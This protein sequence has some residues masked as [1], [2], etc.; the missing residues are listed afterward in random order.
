MKFSMT[1]EVLCELVEKAKPFTRK[2]EYYSQHAT[3]G[4]L[5]EAQG[6]EITASAAT[7]IG[8]TTT[9]PG[10][11]TQ[12]GKVILDLAGLEYF[13]HQ[14]FANQEIFFRAVN[15]TKAEYGRSV[16]IAECVAQV[17][18]TNIHV[19]AVH[20]S[21]FGQMAEL[22]AKEYRPAFTIDA[23]LLIGALGQMGPYVDVEGYSATGLRI[24]SEKRN[25]LT[26]GGRTGKAMGLRTVECSTKPEIPE[27][28]LDKGE[29]KA[30]VTALSRYIKA[31]PRRP[32]LGVAEA[33]A[34]KVT[35][36]VDVATGQRWRVCL[37]EDTVMFKGDSRY[38]A[39]N[40]RGSVATKGRKVELPAKAMADALR[41]LPKEAADLVTLTHGINKPTSVEWKHQEKVNRLALDILGMPVLRPIQLNR[42]LWG[43]V[44]KSFKGDAITLLIPGPDMPLRFT[45]AQDPEL[46]VCVSQIGRETRVRAEVNDADSDEEE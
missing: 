3:S 22:V 15:K 14:Q 26:L 32:S 29:I 33:K 43:T 30:L 1:Q 34:V 4:V 2:G 6:E 20:S 18:D 28:A 45:C 38:E 36:D 31:K 35:F 27:M 17:G 23:G 10:Q 12:A 46:T 42:K 21:Q 11:F 25:Q 5:F 7:S 24:W 39:P 8:M 19:A 40:F 37:G 13:T 9:I 16:R 41:S 44:L